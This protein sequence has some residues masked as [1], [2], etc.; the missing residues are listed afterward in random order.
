MQVDYIIVGAGSAGCIVAE[1]LTRCGRYSVLL[2]EA[3]GGLHNPWINIPAGFGATYYH[4]KY[5]YMYY[6]CLLYTSPS[7]R[8]S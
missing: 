1:Q 6:S 5:N 2:L 4:P 7:P 8:D 3:G